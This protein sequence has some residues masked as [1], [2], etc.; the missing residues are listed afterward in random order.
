MMLF[1]GIVVQVLTC[2]LFKFGF[3][4]QGFCF[5]S[6]LFVFPFNIFSVSYRVCRSRHA[7]VGVVKTSPCV[8][9][10]RPLTLDMCPC[11]WHTRGR[12]ESTTMTTNKTT[13][14]SPHTP[15]HNTIVTNVQ[16]YMETER[17]KREVKT[18]EDER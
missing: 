13:P 9:A 6:F 14:Q 18:R 5:R 10:S 3:F 16:R 11:C 12:S 15:A 17:D 4:V 8:Q 2:F 1:G 7:H